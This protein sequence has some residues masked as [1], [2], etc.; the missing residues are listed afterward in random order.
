MKTKL[1]YVVVSDEKDTFLE[2]ALAAVFTAKFRMP[3]CHV[4]ILT[5]SVTDKTIHGRR[6]DIVAFVD[7]KVVVEFEDSIS[8]K[9]RSRYLKTNMRDYVKGDFLYVDIDTVVLQPLYEI[10]QLEG[11]L[12]AVPDGHVQ[13]KDHYFKSI[14][15]NETR[16]LG[17]DV[18]TL[19]YYYN[20]GVMFVKDTEDT[21][22]FFSNWNEEY[23]RHEM[24]MPQDQPSLNKINAECGLI[25]LLPPEYNMQLMCGLQ[26]MEKAKILHFF[27][28]MGHP[29]LEIASKDFLLSMKETGLT[30]EVKYKLL[31]PFGTF[32][33][34]STIVRCDDFY[35][36]YSEGY[37]VMKQFLMSNS[38]FLGV[39]N[40]F[41]AISEKEIKLISWIN[42]L[43]LLIEMKYITLRAKCS[44][45]HKK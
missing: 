40:R 28:S 26:Y 17:Y 39:S 3:D 9:T 30:D 45:F 32:L 25:Q 27:T 1:V 6:A 34:L 29:M 24:V 4:C 42:K 11:C 10:D 43:I 15:K 31:H 5:D 8:K 35:F 14:V 41:N 19:K 33:P 2:M 36:R 22:N 20:S 37:L 38:E 7:E 18:E 23:K 21:H 44:V 16:K 12:Y 13:V